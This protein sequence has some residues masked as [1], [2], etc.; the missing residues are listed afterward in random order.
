MAALAQTPGYQF[1]LGEGIKALD[2]SAAAKGTLLTGGHL[3]DLT[4][5][6]QGLAS[7][8]F[9]N[10]FGRNF[11]LANLGMGAAGAQG[12]F[13]S[14]YGQNAT[15]LITGAGNAQAAGTAAG[16]QAWGNALGNLGNMGMQAA[17]L[18]GLYGGTPQTANPYAM[19]PVP[20]PF[21]A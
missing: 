7:T 5:F 15:N 9:Q 16:G 2:R 10:E 11:S 12:Q 14:S 4:G 19:A 18:Y 20:N 17:M 13:G 3:K 6:A 21:L 8:E 1:R